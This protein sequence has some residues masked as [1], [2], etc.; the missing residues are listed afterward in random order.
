MFSEDVIIYGKLGRPFMTDF[1][2]FAWMDF[3]IRLYYRLIKIYCHNI[4]VSV[5]YTLRFQALP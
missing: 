5:N 2:G 1:S 4:C 3:F